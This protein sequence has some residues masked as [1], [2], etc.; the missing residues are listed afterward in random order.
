MTRFETLYR[1]WALPIWGFWALA[2]G[3]VLLVLLIVWS[4]V[5]KGIAL[6]K[7][8]RRG[9]KIWFIV[10]LLVNTAGILEILYIYVFSKRKES[11]E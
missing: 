3:G 8:G 6:W 5:W 7:A 10:L 11:G 1:H 2:I 4:M 9:D